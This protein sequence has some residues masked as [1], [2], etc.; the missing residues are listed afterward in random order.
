MF[1]KV[2]V[3]VHA[4]ARRRQWRLPLPGGR[5]GC[6]GGGGGSTALRAVRTRVL[7][8]RRA[9]ASPAGVVVRPVVVVV[10]GVRTGRQ[11]ADAAVAVAAAVVPALR[12]DVHVVRRAQDA[13]AHTHAA[14]PLSAVRQGVLAAV[15]AAGAPAHAHRRAAVLVPAVR[16]RVRRPLQPARA[17][18][19]A[20]RRQAL[21]VCRLPPI[22]LPPL[23]AT[24]PRASLRRSRLL[25]RSS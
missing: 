9:G 17:P 2:Y 8:A 24:P 16:T 1:N 19:D 3:F 15:A 20:R 21:P 7:D 5:G 10:A 11:S 23:S 25:R 18:A 6:G 4:G 22:L 12:E 13:R 14:V